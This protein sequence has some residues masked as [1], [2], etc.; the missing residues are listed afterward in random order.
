MSNVIYTIIIPTHDRGEL[1]KENLETLLPQVRKFQGEVNIFVSD[2]ASK[3]N[4]EQIVK[5][6]LKDNGDILQYHRH[7]KNIGYAANFIFATRKADGKYACLMG[8]DDIML[9]NH[10]E[11]VVGLLKENPDAGIVHFNLVTVGYDLKNGVLHDTNVRSLWPVI[12][13][14]GKEFVYNHLALPSHMSS[15]VF[16]REGFLA[17]FREYKDDEYPGYQWFFTMCRSILE[18]KCIYVGYPLG[19]KRLPIPKSWEV[20]EPWYQIRGLG[21][22]FEELNKYVPGLYARWQQHVRE[23]RTE[24]LEHMLVSATLDKELNRERYERMKPYMISVEYDKRFHDV[25]SK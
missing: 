17:C 20:H 2:N 14:S 25:I 16:D 23:D 11:T 3:D 10:V 18:K 21:S 1:L 8:D 9:P 6:F 7:E 5:P 24:E 13:P 12:Y 15:N 4:T 22:V 19:I